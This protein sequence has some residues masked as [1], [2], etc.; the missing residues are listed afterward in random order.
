MCCS[1]AILWSVWFFSL[2]VSRL[3]WS[4]LASSL[5]CH[6]FLALFLERPQHVFVPR[7][8][9]PPWA[10][11]RD[12]RFT[13]VVGRPV[14]ALRNWFSFLCGYHRFTGNNSSNIR[15][16]NTIS[17]IGSHSKCFLLG[18]HF[19]LVF[20]KQKQFSLCPGL[21]SRQYLYLTFFSILPSLSSSF[22]VQQLLCLA[23]SLSSSLP[24]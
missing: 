10:M 6:V 13:S 12:V 3:S 2:D 16:A 5:R 17:N 11:D 4:S 20:T 18:S 15:F 19:F 21:F 8:V 14:W 23:A 24:V 22:S 9:R 1:L 7:A